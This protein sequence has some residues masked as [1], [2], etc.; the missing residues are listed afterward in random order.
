[1]GNS[2]R[3]KKGWRCHLPKQG[4]NTCEARASLPLATQ[5][6]RV[7]YKDCLVPRVLNMHVFPR[8]WDTRN[9]REEARF[10]KYAPQTQPSTTKSNATVKSSP[11]PRCLESLETLESKRIYFSASSLCPFTRVLLTHAPLPH[12]VDACVFARATAAYSSPFILAST[13]PN[14]HVRVCRHIPPSLGT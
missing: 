13:S 7:Y 9:L 1:M 12:A 5:G 3:R 6:R 2:P 4:Y 11:F 10:C 8:C 14:I